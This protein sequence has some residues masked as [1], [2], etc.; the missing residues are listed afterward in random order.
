MESGKDQLPPLTTTVIKSGVRGLMM[1]GE[2]SCY[3]L[4]YG[5]LK[6]NPRHEITMGQFHQFMPH[7]SAKKTKVKTVERQVKL[8]S[9][10]P[11]SQ[12]GVLG[13]RSTVVG[14]GS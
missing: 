5:I 1:E 9:T 7:H 4:F 2:Y 14:T 12:Y 8:A 6:L 3:P 13:L 10:T 11:Y